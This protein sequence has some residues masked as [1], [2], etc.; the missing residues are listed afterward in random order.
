[1]LDTIY[2]WFP[3][4]KPNNG[5]TSD[6]HAVDRGHLT[7]HDFRLEFEDIVKENGFDFSSH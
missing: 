4:L 1:M 7:D 6:S 5:A 3:F 2:G